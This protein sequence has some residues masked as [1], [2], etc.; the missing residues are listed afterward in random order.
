MRALAPKATVLDGLRFAKKVPD[1]ELKSWAEE[2]MKE[3]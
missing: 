2:K 1:N 3:A